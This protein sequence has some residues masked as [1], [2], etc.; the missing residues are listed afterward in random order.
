[1]VCRQVK[2]IKEI[3]LPI[4]NHHNHWA[5][6][7]RIPL[8]LKMILEVTSSEGIDSTV[9]LISKFFLQLNTVHSQ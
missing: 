9:Q 6:R 7:S 1:V 2:C 5:E 3:H 4:V 8:C